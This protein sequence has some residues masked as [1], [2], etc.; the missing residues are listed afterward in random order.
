M[1]YK[2]DLEI[3]L[4][5]QSEIIAED[6]EQEIEN[7][8]NSDENEGDQAEEA[9]QK[10]EVKPKRIV[11]NPQPKL[12]EETLRGPRG[13]PIMKELFSK[14]KFKGA[15]HEEEDL[16]LLLK[17]YEYW[18]HRMFPLYTFS[19]CVEKIE[20]LGHK[21]A[22]VTYIK[23]IRMGLEESS[24]E[25]DNHEIENE[26]P[27]ITPATE[28]NF[29]MLLSNE[30]ADQRVQ[31]QPSSNIL[32]EEQLEI[33]RLNKERALKIRQERLKMLE[34]QNVHQNQNI[35]STENTSISISETDSIDDEKLKSIQK[36]AAKVVGVIQNDSQDFQ[37]NETVEMINL[38]N[39]QSSSVA[40]ISVIS[41][42][43]QIDKQE[44]V[45]LKPVSDNANDDVIFE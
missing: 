5:G 44:H 33:I 1:E 18:C 3:I 2:D 43:E 25:E 39:I 24:E 20:K 41:D 37:N 6:N 17:T 30:P 13:I 14:Q 27:T 16:K 8:G 29:D 40:E 35:E 38:E 4:D 19:D 22:M 15:G 28:D 7:A 11:R 21:K 10:K 45:G 23:K 12:N 31:S 32:T 42:C 36:T 9:P 34:Q 26:N